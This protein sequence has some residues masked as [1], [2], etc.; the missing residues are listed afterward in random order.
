MTDTITV[1]L[2][3][4]DDGAVVRSFNE[5]LADIVN[6]LREAEA[7][8][9]SV[10][11]LA[12]KLTVTVTI[13]A[14]EDEPGAYQIGYSV[15]ATPPKRSPRT[16]RA[17]D[18]HGVLLESPAPEQGVIMQ[19][20][21][22]PTWRRTETV[23]WLVDGDEFI[24]TIDCPRKNRRNP[25]YLIQAQV[26]TPMSSPLPPSPSLAHAVAAL[27]LRLGDARVPDVPAELAGV[28]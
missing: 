11:K 28:L 17:V 6:D 3:T 26:R 7:G 25:P 13:A 4:L 10:E 9:L 21:S 24:A 14:D 20:P 27:R 2:D 22:A 15:I 12:G 18:D 16:I 8:R 5:K 19:K 23:L 1:S